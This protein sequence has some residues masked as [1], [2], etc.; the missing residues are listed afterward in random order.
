[1]KDKRRYARAYRYPKTTAESR[2][3][4]GCKYARAKRRKANLPDAYWDMPVSKNSWDKSWKLTRKKQYRNRGKKHEIYIESTTGWGYDKEVILLED[5]FRKHNIPYRIDEV[6]EKYTE[7]YYITRK[8]VK[9]CY[10]PYYTKLW[11]KSSQQHQAGWYWTYKWVDL[12]EPIKK[13]CKRKRVLGYTIVWWT[14]KDI[15]IDRILP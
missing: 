14:D 1:M 3:N 8:R 6:G 9:D 13:T 5:Y 10:L 7:V 2:A 15:G 11:C 4:E 12:E